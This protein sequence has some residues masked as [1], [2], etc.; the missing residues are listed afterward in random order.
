VYGNC[1]RAKSSSLRALVSIFHSH[2]VAMTDI[3][4]DPRRSRDTK[5]ITKGRNI[6]ETTTRRPR[7]DAESLQRLPLSTTPNNSSHLIQN[8]FCSRLIMI[9]AIGFLVCTASV[10]APSLLLH[11]APNLSSCDGIKGLSFCYCIIYRDTLPNMI[12]FAMAPI[13][14]YQIQ[15]TNSFLLASNRNQF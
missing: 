6:P 12:M 5:S 2:F 1:F 14:K 8:H 13:S 3:R 7:S 9:L 15:S 4:H 11:T 10:F